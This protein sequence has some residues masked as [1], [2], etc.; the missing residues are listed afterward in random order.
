MAAKIPAVYMRGGTSHGVFFDL[1]D[2]PSHSGDRDRLLAQVMGAPDPCAASAEVGAARARIVLV[3][4]SLRDGCDVDYLYGELG[5]DRQRIDWSAN[6]GNLAGAVGP[7]AVQQGLVA[8]KQGTTVVRIWHASLNRRLL[9][10]V[11]VRDGEVIEDGMFLEDG[12]VFPAAEVRLDYPDDTSA[13]I[14]PTGN[15]QDVLNV[16]GVGAVAATLL[17][18][19][20][21]SVFVRA[22]DVGLTGRELPDALKRSARAMANLEAIRVGAATLM[23]ASTGVRHAARILAETRVVWIAAPVSYKTSLGLDVP[24][25]SVDVLA[26]VLSEGRMQASFDSAGAIS[27]AAATALPGSLV[28][29]VARTLPG[30][31][32]RIGHAS[33]VLTVDASVLWRTQ[34]WVMERASMSRSARFLMSGWLHVPALSGRSI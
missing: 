9:A 4:P 16:H 30:V 18:A 17:L 6:C 19:G 2:L 13:A 11:S 21:P 7:Y 22:A 8:A 25:A 3:G 32:T 20:A 28:A 23:G 5:G 27:M 10:H 26:R 15:V 34:G 33:G 1:R 31:G 14:L 24:Q 29:Q 12:S